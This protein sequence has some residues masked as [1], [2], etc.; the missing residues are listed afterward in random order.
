MRIGEPENK[1]ILAYHHREKIEA[2]K[3]AQRKAAY[4]VETLGKKPGNVIRIVR[5]E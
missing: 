3:A 5:R 4:W 2:M 1:D